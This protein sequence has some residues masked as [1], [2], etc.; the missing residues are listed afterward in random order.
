MNPRSVYLSRRSFQ[1]PPLYKKNGLLLKLT[2]LCFQRDKHPLHISG[3][4]SLHEEGADLAPKVKTG[5]GEKR[6]LQLQVAELTKE[7][8]RL[9]VVATLAVK[10][11]KEA[12]AQVLAEI[13]KHD[14]LQARFTRL[15]GKHFDLTHKMER[16]QLV[17][18][19]IFEYQRFAEFRLE[20]GK[21]AIYCLCLFTK[22]YRDVNP[23]IV[24]NYED[25]I[26]DYPKEWFASLD[27]SIPLSPLAKEEEDEEEEA[28]DPF[29]SR[30]CPHLLVFSDF[31]PCNFVFS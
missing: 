31:L 23:P 8:E 13:K 29:S 9:K 19:A 21:E 18:R 28:E 6:A 4:D 3:L 16:L 11:K 5:R 25:F 27:I 22:T 10:E 24:A 12:T 17:Q 30:Q 15:E 1:N 2:P 14:L 26:Q 20:A 7:N